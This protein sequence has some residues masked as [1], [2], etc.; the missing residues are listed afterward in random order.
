[1]HCLAVHSCSS[2]PSSPS[3]G[4]T[5][6][7]SLYLPNLVLQPH[8]C[9][10]LVWCLIEVCLFEPVS[11]LLPDMHGRVHKHAATLTEAHEAHV[12]WN[13]HVHGNF[14][15]CSHAITDMYL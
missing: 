11:I 2:G 1:M 14:S 9:C 6:K 15:T 4:V 3:V 7:R 13:R 12:H 5:P 8:L 10:S